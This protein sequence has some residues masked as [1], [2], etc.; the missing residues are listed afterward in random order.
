MLGLVQA[1]QGGLEIIDVTNPAAPIEIGFTS[2]TGE[3]HT[4]NI[5]PKR[6]HIAIVSSSDTVTVNTNGPRANEDPPSS[7]RFDL[8]SIEIVDLSQVP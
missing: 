2:H 6:P 8:N 4:V 5:D 3:A 7:E 1:P